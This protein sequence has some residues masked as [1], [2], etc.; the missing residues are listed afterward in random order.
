[1]KA[2]HGRLIPR[3]LTS[4]L[5]LSILSIYRLSILQKYLKTATYFSC[6]SSTTPEGCHGGWSLQVYC[7]FQL[8]SRWKSGTPQQH[9]F[10]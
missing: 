2:E 10:L 5:G 9:Q 1:M 7:N 3:K 6:F 4:N 8:E